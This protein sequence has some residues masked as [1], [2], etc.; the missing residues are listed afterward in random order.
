MPYRELPP[1]AEMSPVF[2]EWLVWLERLQLKPAHTRRAYSQGIRRVLSYTDIAAGDFRPDSFNQVTLTDTVR[3]ILIDPKVSRATLSQTLA[4]L[5]SFY[6]FCQTDGLLQSVPDI[7]LIREASQAGRSW[8]TVEPSY[9]LPTQIQDLYQ[10]ANSADHSG[11]SGSRVRWPSR[12]LAMCSFLAILGLRSEEL[13]GATIGSVTRERLE[14]ATNLA[15]WMIQIRGKGSKVRHLPLSQELVSANER[16]QLERAERFGT[17]RPEDP[18][19]VTRNGA[20]F[21]YQQLR[22][23]LRVLNRQAGL[24]SYSL[25]KLRHTAGVQMAA[26]GVPMNVIQG[27]LGHVTLNTTGIYTELAG[28]QLVGAPEK[29]GANELLGKT[30][31]DLQDSGR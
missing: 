12:D 5:R 3:D 22:Y 28:G 21:S 9:Y 1:A 8:S 20:R 14:D 29:T 16:W 31:D 10:E 11:Q 13:I 2:H 6:V 15:T 19:F 24:P 17:P 26:A 7:E 4:A 30:L 18:L 25:H 23:W 27:M